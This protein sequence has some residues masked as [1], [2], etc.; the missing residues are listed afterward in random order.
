MTYRL[1]VDLG[2]TF[3]AAAVANGMQPTMLGLGNRALQIPSVLFLNDDGSILVGE[4][5]ERRGLS[6]PD[7]VVREFK[8]RIGDTVPILVA[9]RPF[10]PQAL[11]SRLLQHVVSTATER[12]GE[13]PEQVVLTH[14]ANWGP[15]KLE[16]LD[17]V[18]RMAGV[19]RLVRCPEP[20]AAAAQY[21]SQTRV[22]VG[23]T[24]AVYDLGG[25]T[26]DACVLQKTLTGFALLGTPEGI[27]H[28]GGVDFDEAL[29]QHVIGLLGDRLVSIDPDDPD[30]M[31]GLARLRRDCVDAKEALSSDTD[32][33]LPV[34]LPG[35]STTLRLTRG[36]FENLIRPALGDT[37]S[38]LD[39][40]VRSSGRTPDE[41]SAIVLV[42]GSSRIPLI[43]ELLHQSFA[44]QTA[45]DTHPKHD[46]A[47]GAVQL[48]QDGLAA[49]PIDVSGPPT[50]RTPRVPPP[51][52]PG[53]GDASTLPATTVRSEPAPP[54]PPP[55]PGGAVPPS[56]LAGMPPPPGSPPPGTGPQRAAPDDSPLG[57]ASSAAGSDPARRRRLIILAACAAAV[58]A[59]IVIGVVVVSGRGDRDPIGGPVSET[60]LGPEPSPSVTPTSSSPSP[61]T[62]GPATPAGL[63]RS[64]PLEPT[65]MLIQMTTGDDD[66]IWVGDT[67]TS[68]PVRQLTKGDSYN[69]AMDISPAYDSMIYVHAD[70]IQGTNSSLRVAG[71]QGL[72]GDRQLFRRPKGCSQFNRPAW[73]P[74]DP[75]LLAVPCI[76]EDRRYAIFVMTTAG[77]VVKQIKPPAGLPRLGDV[78]YSADGKRLCFWAASDADKAFD[79]GVL[80]TVA[81]AGGT[82]QKLLKSGAPTMKGSDADPSYSPDG[83]YVAFRRRVATSPGKPDQTDIYRVNVDGTGLKQLTRDPTSEQNPT[84][85]PDSQQIAYKSAAASPALPTSDF[86]KIW[87]MTVDGQQQRPLWTEGRIGAQALA[88]WA[89]R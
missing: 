28:L 47:L 2:T 50:V 11:T 70:D 30:T 46:V 12:M 43:G 25:G 69:G 13:P 77:K 41:L 52:P 58:I 16:L 49:V 36:E 45:I 72:E 32:A 85:S 73:N 14:P 24:I 7:R 76:T 89:P 17:Q 23:D 57:P 38:A 51:V 61:T 80:Y 81:V 27:E 66:Q 83:A 86:L 1:G 53:G 31:V 21:A 67:Q 5:A 75:T 48:D 88:A 87:V 10:S 29:F 65:Q 63:P 18:A 59:G 79:G 35:L 42:G 82:P 84:W 19:E 60:T 3:T 71:V 9:G 40:A 20:L 55:V 39:R 78:V 15:Y 26:F 34:A 33:M 6:Q 22:E 62:R 44:T 8:R 4:T 56:G 68:S 37:I 74:A 54:V 64:A